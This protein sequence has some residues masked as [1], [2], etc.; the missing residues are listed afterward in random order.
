MSCKNYLKA[1]P[2]RIAMAVQGS[3]KE[4]AKRDTK[5]IQLQS[6]LSD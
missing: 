1:W 3:Q 2:V 5:M 6:I 4:A